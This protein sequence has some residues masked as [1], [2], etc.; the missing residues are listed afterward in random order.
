[1]NTTI[2]GN[3]PLPIPYCCPLKIGWPNSINHHVISS[4]TQFLLLLM[5]FCRL[6]WMT[7]YPKRNQKKKKEK[8]KKKKYK[9]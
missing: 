2:G 1:M 9:K 4:A 7:S 3:A 5:L 6:T 8:K